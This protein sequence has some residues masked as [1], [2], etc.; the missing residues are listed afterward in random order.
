LQQLQVVGQLLAG[1]LEQKEGL[2]AITLVDADHLLQPS[3]EKVSRQDTVDLRLTPTRTALCGSASTGWE[4]DI[5]H[6][7]VE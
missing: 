2:T 5:V 6:L 7:I 3:V 1:L 4:I